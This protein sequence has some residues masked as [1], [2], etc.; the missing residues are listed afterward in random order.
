MKR[1]ICV[2]LLVAVPTAALARKRGNGR[3]SWPTPAL[4]KSAS[5]Q[6]EV[7]FTFD[8]GPGGALT[9][10]LL[11][12]LAERGVHAIF[13]LVGNRVSGGKQRAQQL[14]A[15]MLD[16][17]HAVGNHTQNH[18]DL[19]LA[20][21]AKKIDKEID[22]SQT[23]IE[24]ATSM[25]IVLFRAPFG[26]RCTPLEQALDARRLT[27]IHWDI[28]PQEWKT[29]DAVTTEHRIVAQI[30]HLRDGERAVV[31]AH[32]IHPE[33]IHAIPAV[34]TWIDQEN[35]RRRGTGKKEIRII[36]PAEIALEKLLPGVAGATGDA[37]TTVEQF[38]DGLLR[39][40][41]FPLAGVAAVQL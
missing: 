16:E 22:D 6:P 29:H 34:L 21:Q 35:A 24:Q 39:R 1:L 32:D 12:I 23:L 37:A 11:D 25:S 8:D 18:K 41:V 9:G 5:G 40:L 10:E 28:D 14:I 26:V 19:C 27:H 20:R 13:F 33:T 17:G 31:L 15:R 30:A 2:L 38:G 3:K 4:G 7:L 36:D